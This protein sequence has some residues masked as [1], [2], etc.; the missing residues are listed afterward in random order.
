M[1]YFFSYTYFFSY[2]AFWSCF[3]SLQTPPRTSLPTQPH[4]FMFFLLFMFFFFL[5]SRKI[6][7][8]QQKVQAQKQ[9]I[10][11]RKQSTNKTRSAKMKQKVHRSK[12]GVPFVLATCSWPWACSAMWLIYPVTFHWRKLVFPFAS[13]CQLQIASRLG[14][15][16][17]LAWTCAGLMHSHS[18]CGFTWASVL[19]SRNHC[20]L[21]V[22]HH[23]WLLQFFC[24]LFHID[25]WALRERVWWKH[26]ICNKCSKVSLFLHIVQLQKNLSANYQLTQEEASPVRVEWGTEL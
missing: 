20:F 26:P 21:A 19:C 18:P 8:Q 5:S 4:N 25:F 12:H 7:Q 11:T 9:K 22:I 10:K 2:S 17:I 13:G 3:S 16:P 6:Q 15:G 24:L 23:V 14:V 1:L